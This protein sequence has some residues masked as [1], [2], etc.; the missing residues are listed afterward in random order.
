MWISD[1][2]IHTANMP[3]DAQLLLI[4]KRFIVTNTDR[5]AQMSRAFARLLI[6]GVG[7]RARGFVT[8]S[9]TYLMF[10]KNQYLLVD[11]LSLVSCRIPS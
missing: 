10:D 7:F 8:D 1:L 11:T 2:S 6:S 5:S 3:A 4:F 9:P